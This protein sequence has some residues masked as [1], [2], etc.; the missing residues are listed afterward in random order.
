[1]SESSAPASGTQQARQSP[2]PSQSSAS[3]N[4]AAPAAAGVAQAADAVG[5]SP[6]SSQHPQHAHARMTQ[7]VVLVAAAACVAAFWWVGN[8]LDVPAHRGYEASLL[9]QP[10]VAGKVLAVLAAG[11]LFVVCVVVGE[12]VAGRHWLYAGP[13]AAAIGLAVLSVRG[14]PSRYVYLYADTT[15]LGRGVLLV[16]LLEVALLFVFVGATWYLLTREAVAQLDPQRPVGPLSGTRLQG[17]AT[18]VALMAFLVM[19]LTPTDQKGQ[20]MAAVFVAAFIATSAAEHFFVEERLGAWWWVGPLAVGA[21]GYGAS[22]FLASPEVLKTGYVAGTLAPLAR[23]L[24]LDYA[25][26]GTAGALLGYWFGVGER[27]PTMTSLVLA[28]PVFGRLRLQ[29][30]HETPA[31]SPVGTSGGSG[32]SSNGQAR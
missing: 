22:Y 29:A 30:R 31:T 4:P 19:V 11:V 10:A 26:A 15:G 16:L 18:Q 5:Q 23:P 2:P 12:L 21:I 27:H 24:P 25:S 28:G 9:L 3:Q 6:P 17:L 13:F 8:L 7:V 32:G 1:M 20:A 14:G